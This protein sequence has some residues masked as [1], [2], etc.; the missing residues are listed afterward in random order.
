MEVWFEFGHLVSYSFWFGAQT[1]L[2]GVQGFV[3]RAAVT[4]HQFGY[5]M[6]KV[7]PAFFKTGSTSA[8]ISIGFF[9]C[10]RPSFLAWS[11]TE[12]LQVFQVARAITTL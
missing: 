10:A 1:W 6:S 12:R 3:L 2:L 7:F 9:V 5:I 11:P 4:R 8:L